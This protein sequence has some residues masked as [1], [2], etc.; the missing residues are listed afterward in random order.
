MKFL[1]WNILQGGGTRAE[2]IAEQIAT[3]QPDI[4]GLSEFRGTKPSQ[5]IANALADSGLIHQ[6][7]T[8]NPDKPNEYRLLLE[9]R[10]PFEQQPVQGLLH[11]TGRWLHVRLPLPLPLDVI[12]LHIPTR[13]AGNKYQFQDAVIAEFQSLR[14]REVVAF[15]DTN[16]GEPGLDEDAKFFNAREADWFAQV[17]TSG[18]LDVWRHRNPDARK[19]TWYWNNKNGFRID[20]VFA[21]TSLEP[22]LSSV[23]Y[24]WGKIGDV[25]LSDHAAVLFDVEATWI[26]PLGFG[27]S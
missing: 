17:R 14:N 6:A 1:S 3:W 20:Q 27:L 25:N 9:S 2:R 5:R 23:Q 19:F 11:E 12:V 4:V 24:E 16:T 7:T 18:W 13:D 26:A 15:G 10:Y 21:T 22:R 8:V